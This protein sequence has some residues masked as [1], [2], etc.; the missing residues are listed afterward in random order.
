MLS[1]WLLAA[2]LCLMTA[3]MQAAPARLLLETFDKKAVDQQPRTQQ[4]NQHNQH[5]L[6]PDLTAKVDAAGPDGSTALKVSYQ[7]YA[8]GSER[9]AANWPLAAAV[10][11]AELSFAV[12]FCP[13]FKFVKGGKLHGLGP[14][15]PITGGKAVS[16]AGWSVRL[17]FGPDGQLGAYVYHQA[18]RKTFGQHYRAKD[19]R[20]V[21]GRYYQ[22]KLQVALNSGA[23]RD[24]GWFRLYADD[25]L[26]LEQ[27][28]LQFR[29]NTVPESQ[30]SQLLIN[31]FH[32]GSSVAYAPREQ[33]GRFSR[34][35]AFF[36]N[37]EVR[38]LPAAK[39]KGR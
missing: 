18:L 8:R 1:R 25:K 37:F 11:A 3:D 6:P 17:S 23:D 7:G 9:I 32:G 4:H 16:A 27:Q 33:D 19:F 36:D 29:A 24:D 30:I 14:A 15:T 22:L 20:L 34:E 12:K 2:V 21:P 13:D 28:K 10:P 39:L 5:L 31:T 26:V 35:C 38:T